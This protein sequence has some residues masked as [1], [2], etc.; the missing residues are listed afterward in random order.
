M[1]FC[2]SRRTKGRTTTKTFT[3]FLLVSPLA[4]TYQVRVYTN[5]A[6]IAS[7]DIRNIVKTVACLPA[8]STQPIELYINDIDLDVVA[9][10]IILLLIGLSIEDDNEAVECMIHVWYSAFLRACDMAILRDRIRPMIE[11]VCRQNKDKSPALVLGKTWEFAQDS[12][13]I[14][15]TNEA[16]GKV[17][18]H[19]DNSPGL[20]TEPAKKLRSAVTLAPER[21][22]FL[23]RHM[24]TLTP[25]HR[26]CEQRFREDGVLLPFGASRLEFSVPNP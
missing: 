10:N 4:Q 12:C 16:W 5:I 19:L 7:G 8:D 23:H 3:F 22:D 18:L 17:L 11:D 25:A 6:D 9:R 21:V 14:E 15:L 26:I 13:R 2:S 24:L 1:M 20:P